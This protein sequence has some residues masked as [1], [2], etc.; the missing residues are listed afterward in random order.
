MY[1]LNVFIYSVC[2]ILIKIDVENGTV[3]IRA[4]FRCLRE[5]M[6]HI[7]FNFIFRRM[8]KG[9]K[10]TKVVKLRVIGIVNCVA[11]GIF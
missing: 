10:Q 4:I 8:E 1:I 6:W 5:R 9:R 7:V 3:E 11:V 2:A